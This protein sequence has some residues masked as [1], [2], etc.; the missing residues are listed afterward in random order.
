MHL[1]C[2]FLTY[3]DFLYH[4]FLKGIVYKLVCGLLVVHFGFILNHHSGKYEVWYY[5]LCICQCHWVSVW[6]CCQVCI[7]LCVHVM[8]P[9]SYFFMCPRTTVSV[10]TYCGLRYLESWCHLITKSISQHNIKAPYYHHDAYWKRYKNHRRGV[11]VLWCCNV[12]WGT[13]KTAWMIEMSGVSQSSQRRVL[14][15]RVSCQGVHNH[16]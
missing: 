6:C 7:I 12:L 1:I 4:L 3:V 9:G 11:I 2:L 15:W 13:V 14:S 10:S 5:P 8:C 16:L